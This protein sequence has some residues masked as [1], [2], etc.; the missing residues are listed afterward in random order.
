MEVLVVI[1]AP[2][3]LTGLLALV[4][5]RNSGNKVVLT[6]VLTIYVVLGFIVPAVVGVS[7]L[8][9]KGE[10]EQQVFLLLI[11]VGLKAGEIFSC[12]LGLLFRA[13]WRGE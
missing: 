7:I 10:S 13:L 5:Y 2:L 9:R 6:V 8:E 1:V 12:R 11:L 3:V 4:A